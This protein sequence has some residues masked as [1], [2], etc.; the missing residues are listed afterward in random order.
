MIIVLRKTKNQV[1]AAGGTD[2]EKSRCKSMAAHG[3]LNEIERAGL[4]P[5]SYCRDF[6]RVFGPETAKTLM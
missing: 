2:L 3:C 6:N 1:F 5:A 4:E